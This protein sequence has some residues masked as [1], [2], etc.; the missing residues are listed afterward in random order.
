MEYSWHCTNVRPVSTQSIKNS[1]L[2]STTQH[3]PNSCQLA[4]SSNS[5]VHG[6]T[7]HSCVQANAKANQMSDSSAEVAKASPVRNKARPHGFNYEALIQT[8]LH[9]G[10]RGVD[11]RCGCQVRKSKD[12]QNKEK[13]RRHRAGAEST[14]QEAG[15]QGQT[16]MMMRRREPCKVVRTMGAACL[17]MLFSPFT[18]R[19]PPRSTSSSR[20]YPRPAYLR[21]HPCRCQACSLNGSKQEREGGDNSL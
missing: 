13:G 12:K 14:G 2:L 15:A 5:E 10:V 18:S 4:T 9:Y 1:N 8:Q 6:M 19:A 3:P 11:T 21:P 7:T 20:S 17:H 16:C